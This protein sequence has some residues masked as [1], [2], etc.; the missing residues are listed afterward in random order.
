M[1]I[2]CENFIHLRRNNLFEKINFTKF[3]KKHLEALQFNLPYHNI[4]IF[5]FFPQ[6][7]LETLNRKTFVNFYKDTVFIKL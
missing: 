4:L 6:N 1:R 7:D 3:I 5:T 2:V